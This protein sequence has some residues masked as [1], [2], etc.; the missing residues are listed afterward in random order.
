[1]RGTIITFYCLATVTLVWL[2]LLCEK[3]ISFSLGKLLSRHS[4]L[5]VC[6]RRKVSCADLFVHCFWI[7][8][9]LYLA[10]IFSSIF[11]NGTIP[12]FFEMSC[13]LCYPEPEGIIGGFLTVLNTLVGAL[14]LLVLDI[15]NVG[16][17]LFVVPPSLF[18]HQLQQK[19]A[20]V[21]LWKH[22]LRN[23]W[24]INLE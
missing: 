16:K 11:V 20:C 5:T 14:F 22:L 3:Y 2:L 10:V 23:C 9:S 24:E 7:S 8:V 13:E 6:E 21:D 15:P 1:M 18:S 12:V 4:W 17:K 19:S